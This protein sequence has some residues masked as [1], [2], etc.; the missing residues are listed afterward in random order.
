MNLTTE[1]TARQSRFS[2]HYRRDLKF[3]YEL[4]IFT[5]QFSQTFNQKEE[6]KKTSLELHGRNFGALPFRLLTRAAYWLSTWPML[7]GH[8][9]FIKVSDII[10]FVP[11]WAGGQ[12]RRKFVC[13]FQGI[14]VASALLE[15]V[16]TLRTAKKLIIPH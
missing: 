13:C 11:V 8:V 4:Q 16:L 1:Y 6:K 5:S 3:V 2:P 9:F 14:S 15:S 12:L 7:G 10:E